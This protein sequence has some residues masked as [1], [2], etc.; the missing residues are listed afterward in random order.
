M[1]PALPYLLLIAAYLIGSIPFSFLVVKI[2][3]GADI[4][5]HGSRN[6]GATNVARTFGKVPGLIALALDIAKG[7]AAVALA[8]WIVQR[9]DW[10]LAPDSTHTSALYSMS[11]WI[12]LAALTAVLAHMFPVWLRFHG[13]KGVATATGAFLALDPL[14]IAAGVIVFLIVILATRFV[15]LASILSAASVPIF[16]RFLVHA[17]FW[18]I[19]ISVVM[20][21]AIILKHH[22]NIARLAQGTERRMGKRDEQ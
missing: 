10:P 11:L 21:F 14:A 9:R 13:G 8:A 5:H 20:A 6:V 12:S 3:A 1:T 19:V 15:S 7:Y 17:S 18:T 16:M 22:S 4:R 2:A